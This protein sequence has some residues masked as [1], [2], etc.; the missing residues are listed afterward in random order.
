[1]SVAVEEGGSRSEPNS[2]AYE[3]WT[4]CLSWL[5][6]GWLLSFDE[7]ELKAGLCRHCYQVAG[8]ALKSCM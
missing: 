7:I 2:G 3:S 6:K 1:M 5:P 4:S 8:Q